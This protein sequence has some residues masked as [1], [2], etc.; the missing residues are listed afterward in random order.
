MSARE[1][2]GLV[3]A[4]ALVAGCAGSQAGAAPTVHRGAKADVMNELGAALGRGGHRCTVDEDGDL[5]CD[6]DKKDAPTIVVSYRSGAGGIHLTFVTAFP[7]RRQDPCPE[8][9]HAVNAFNARASSYYA[10]CTPIAL[11]LLTML[12]VPETGLDDHD[13]QAFMNWWAPTAV[14]LAFNSPLAS[15]LK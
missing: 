14:Q 13:V 8:L 2:A 5:L 12:V 10:V 4:A 6:A 15:E 9:A 3:I 7:W 11:T 1:G